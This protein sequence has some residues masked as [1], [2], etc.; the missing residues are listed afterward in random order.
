V[1]DLQAIPG[2][3][4]IEALRGEFTDALM[5]RDHDRF[6][7]L[8]TDD[9]RLSPIPDASRSDIWSGQ[10]AVTGSRAESSA[11]SRACVQCV[12]ARARRAGVL[13][14]LRARGAARFA[15]GSVDAT[16]RN[17]SRIAARTAFVRACRNAIR[18]AG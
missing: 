17:A 5:M 2:R 15:P 7:S 10:V 4:E 13:R 14:R 11:R 8:F 9:N 18:T 16:L 12:A 3:V 1:R 6:A